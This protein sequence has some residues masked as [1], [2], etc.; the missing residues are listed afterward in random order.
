MPNHERLQAVCAI[1]AIWAALFF[2]V[3]A[4]PQYVP[5]PWNWYLTVIVTVGVLIFSTVYFGYIKRGR[6][7]LSEQELRRKRE[8]YDAI[9][10]WVESPIFRFQDQRD[11]LP[12]AEKPP[13]LASAIEECL[14]QNYSTIWS[15]LQRLREKYHEYK[16]ANISEIATRYVDG[17]PVYFMDR[18]KAYEHARC[19]E[20]LAWHRQVRE[21][22]ESKILGY[23][24]TRLK[25]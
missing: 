3:L 14:R 19:Q 11:T 6:Q 10:E 15:S 9:K 4:I 18:A 2:G 20:L 21:E 23:D 8:I 16:N 12:L 1:I 25:C 7:E 24:S 22:I 13:R 5:S 17:Q